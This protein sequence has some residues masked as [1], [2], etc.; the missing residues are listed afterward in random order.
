MKFMLSYL[1]RYKRLVAACL[2]LKLLG[3]ILELLIPYVLEYMI[4]EVAP[5]QQMNLVLLWGAVM[6]AL[7][8]LTRIT[9]VSANRL[10]VKSARNATYEIRRDLFWHSL[11]LSGSQTD[12]FGLPSLTSRMTSDSYNVQSFLQSG[13]ALGV[14]APIMLVGGIVITMTMDAGLSAILCVMAPIMLVV[15]VAVSLWGIPLYDKVQQSVDE[16]VRIMRENITGIRVVKALSKEDYER[17]R[18]GAAN[19][20]MA[21]RERKAGIV[22]ALPG[23]LM[24]M[25]LNIGL[26][27]VVVVGA[28]RVNNGVTKPGVILAFLTYFN[29][30]LMGVMGLN[31]VFMMMSK[32]SASARRIKA[33]IDQ[34]EGLA[35]IPDEQ[36]A[37]TDRDGFIVF[38]HVSFRYGEAEETLH[39]EGQRISS[40]ESMPEAGETSRSAMKAEDDRN[41]S[42]EMSNHIADGEP[43]TVDAQSA[44]GENESRQSE[45]ARETSSPEGRRISRSKEE[46]EGIQMSLSELTFTMKKG[47]S[48]GII[49]ATGC[50]K[51]TVINLLMRFYDPTGGHVF[52]DGKDVRT[53]EKD[54]LR[55][56]FGVVFQND[57]IFAESLAKN[58]DFGRGVDA[59]GIRTA[60]ANARAQDFI[61][62]YDDGYQHQ[63]AIHGANLSGGQ[64]QRVLIARAL[65]AHPEIL[66]LD[67]A[68]SALDYKTDA[69][70]RKVIREEYRD[71]TTIVVA[72]RIS[73]IMS[74]D[75][76]IM[77]DEG[78]VIGHGTHEEL[79]AS[80]PKYREIYHTQMG[81]GR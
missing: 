8:A 6:L 42:S 17:R 32:A 2:S 64:R 1:G 70:L 79:M 4:D 49:G 20:T 38:D 75:D 61:E 28:I 39:P 72:Q 33:V 13:Q 34:P 74:L 66:I 51:T 57:V 31:R 71:T 18:F 7:A 59:D 63:A 76:I 81:E 15:T 47:G 5:T 22:M 54:D 23:P 30:I 78:D 44:C 69:A 56:K 9:N 60:A 48:L 77:L 19:E 24:T 35:A 25:A 55:R 80:C 46:T 68:S 52:V 67:D 43:T 45:L 16:I 37:H 41:I 27:I 53:Y 36:A 3:T 21:R 26:T 12:V 73:S 40:L 10:S 58:I 14:R 65:A 29:M 62:A 50:G 11:N